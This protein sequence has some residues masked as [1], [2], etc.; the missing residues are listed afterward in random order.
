[1]EGL[2]PATL[3]QDIELLVKD[4]CRNDRVHQQ[5]TE[6]AQ[7]S[8]IAEDTRSEFLEFGQHERSPRYI[9]RILFRDT[10]AI[11]DIGQA[12][13]FLD[14]QEVE[15][16]AVVDIIDQGRQ[17]DGKLREGVGGVIVH[18]CFLLFLV[19]DLFTLLDNDTRK[20]LADRHCHVTSMLEIMERVV[21]VRTC[22]HS[23]I[24]A[25]LLG[26]FFAYGGCVGG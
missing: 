19:A 24:F 3:A 16:S 1:M 23:D 6:A 4:V 8:N 11:V 18:R 7:F 10:L 14:E 12:L 13:L 5:L 2:L 20:Q 17:Y 22:N 26:G 21:A 15:D 25:Q 9:N